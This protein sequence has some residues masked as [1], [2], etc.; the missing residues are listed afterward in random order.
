LFQGP[1]LSDRSHK[2]QIQLFKA[3]VLQAIIPLFTAYAPIALCC[4]LPFFGLNLP[5]FSVICPP[6]CAMHPVLDSCIMLS[7]VSQFRKTLI[8][9]VFC[10]RGR[11]NSKVFAL[12]V[13]MREVPIDVRHAKR[14]LSDAY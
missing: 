1:H 10:R 4:A 8:D 13:E 7:T 11:R 14:R 5:I 12:D 9:C 6:F 3:L 2:L